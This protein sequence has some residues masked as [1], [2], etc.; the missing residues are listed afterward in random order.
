LHVPRRSRYLIVVP[1]LACSM[2]RTLL[3]TQHL[4]SVRRPQHKMVHSSL[5]NSSCCRRNVRLVGT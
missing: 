5:I 4:V 2:G 1:M 3:I